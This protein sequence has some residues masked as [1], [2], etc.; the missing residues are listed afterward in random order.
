MRNSKPVI[1]AISTND[2][3]GLNFKNI[4]TL[5]P[6]Q[7]VYFVPFGQD[8]SIKKT[9]S[10]VADLSKVPETIALALDHIQI[11]PVL[12]EY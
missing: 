5:M 2:G 6:N 9:N 7:H 11:Q 12:I 3:L 10:L 1:V 8:D 4:G